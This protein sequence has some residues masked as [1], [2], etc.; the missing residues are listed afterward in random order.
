MTPNET[1]TPTD[2]CGFDGF[3]GFDGFE[4]GDPGWPILVVDFEDGGPTLVVTDGLG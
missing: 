3:D 4:C 2:E 1:D